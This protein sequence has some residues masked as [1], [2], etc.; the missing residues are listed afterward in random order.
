MSSSCVSI[1]TAPVAIGRDVFTV[2]ATGIR[3]YGAICDP[4]PD[5]AMPARRVRLPY[6]WWW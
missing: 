5:L 3:W 6:A 1:L 2:L 4:R